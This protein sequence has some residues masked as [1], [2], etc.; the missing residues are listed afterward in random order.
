MGRHIGS[1]NKNKPERK[2]IVCG[3]NNIRSKRKFC[4]FKCLGISMKGKLSPMKGKKFPKEIREK[5]SKAK[6]GKISLVKGKHWKLSLK[7]REN[8][9]NGSKKGSESPLWRGGIDNINHAIRNSFEYRLWRESVFERDNWTCIWCFK[10][11]GKLNADHIKPFCNYPELRF[12]ID[13]GRTLCFEC[14]KTTETY[15]RK[16]INY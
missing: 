2:C 15:G 1:K 7:S 11:G 14:H 9:R 4:S 13:N 3:Q 6:K 16:A 8:I 12:A 5:M 10:K